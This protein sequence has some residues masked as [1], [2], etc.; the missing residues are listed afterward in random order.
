MVAHSAICIPEVAQARQVELRVTAQHSGVFNTWKMWLYPRQVPSRLDDHVRASPAIHAVLAKR[1]PRLGVFNGTTNDPAALL[2]VRN[3]LEPGVAEALQRGARVLCL[4]LPGHDPIKPGTTLGEWAYSAVGSQAGSRL[5]PHAA[6]TGLALDSR[7]DQGWFRLIDDAEQLEQDSPCLGLEPLI[8]GAGKQFEYKAGVVGYPLNFQYHAFQARVGNGRL[9]ACG[10][11][12]LSGYPEADAMLD[13]LLDYARSPDFAPQAAFDLDR[14]FRC[15]EPRWKPQLERTRLVIG[16]QPDGQ[17]WI[18]GAHR[19][20]TIRYTTDGQQPGPTSPIYVTPFPLPQ[21][22]LVRAAATVDGLDVPAAI[23][24]AEFR[25]DKRAWRFV[26]CSSRHLWDNR[27]RALPHN[28][29][30]DDPTTYWT[31]F[32][33]LKSTSAP[34]QDITIDM[35]AEVSVTACSLTPRY[36]LKAEMG[37]GTTAMPAAGDMHLSQDGATWRLAATA[38]FADDGTQQVVE[39]PTTMTAR[40][41]RFTATELSPGADH[42]ALAGIDVRTAS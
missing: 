33:K 31:T 9:L 42:V 15:M 13:R 14:F 6:F 10:L 34:P 26:S 32:D 27:E 25:A 17:V 2:V 38:R 40:F 21:G 11:N 3:L 18:R 19:N 36:S 7:L 4:S 22:G 20:L 24:H 28:I 12:L 5:V 23:A 1:H 41:I 30:N 16:R 37:T 8:V 29:C 35:G 39:L